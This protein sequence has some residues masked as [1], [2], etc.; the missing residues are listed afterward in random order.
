MILWQYVHT[1]ALSKINVGV[2][3]HL[4][5]QI[6]ET[7]AQKFLRS[8][9]AAKAMSPVRVLQQALHCRAVPRSKT[10]P[11]T[12]TT[13]HD[14]QIDPA[15]HTRLQKKISWLCR[16]KWAKLTFWARHQTFTCYKAMLVKFIEDIIMNI[17]HICRTLAKHTW[18]E[19]TLQKFSL[20]KFG[21]PCQ[22]FVNIWRTKRHFLRKF[23]IR[24]GQK[25]I[26]RVDLET[27]GKKYT[28]TNIGFDK[29]ENES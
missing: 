6:L 24:A 26:N 13:D 11:T 10:T 1:L 19:I 18:A 29:A 20:I 28:L 22:M 14:E 17:C 9:P 2:Q 21:K 3:K 12:T 23:V 25:C 5:L 16:G 15:D 4:L 7:C 27:R 8:D